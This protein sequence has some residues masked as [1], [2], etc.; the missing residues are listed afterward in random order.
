MNGL[1]VALLGPSYPFKG[2]IAQYTTYLYRELAARH[3]VLFVSFRRQYPG[4]LYPGESDRDESH[5]ELFEKK[6]RPLIDSLNPLSWR[7]AVREICQFDPEVVIFPWW[8]MFWAPLYLYMTW[9]LRRQ[10][11]TVRVL[12]LCHNVVAHEPSWLSRT[13]TRLTLERGD[14]FIVQSDQDEKAL[15]TMLQQPPL[16]KVEHPAYT[17]SAEQRWP[18]ERARQELGLEGDVLLFFGFIRP[19]KGLDLLLQAMPLIL[20]KRPCTLVI[21]GELWGNRETYQEQL[22]E[23]DIADNV[24]LEDNYIPQERVALYFG[25]CDLVVLPYRSATGS[26]VVKLAHS[27]QRPVVVTD[28]GALPTAVVEEQ[29]GYIVPAED[30]E[31]LAAAILCHFERGEQRAMES[32]IAD[33]VQESDW[34]RLVEG[35]QELSADAAAPLVR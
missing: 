27:Y 14:A 17:V 20:S 30:A 5:T 34:Q 28:V 31:A 33:H 7:R 10:L 2:G 23:L 9:S 6:A 18:R 4:W 32:Y 25:A 26:G 1:R 11:P 15:C 21:A 8:V 29:S 24:L 12:F 3:E 16:R 19:Y 13:L 22:A 35:I